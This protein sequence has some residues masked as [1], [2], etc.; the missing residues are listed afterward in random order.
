MPGIDLA[1][2][3]DRT[4]RRTLIERFGK[5]FVVSTCH[6]EPGMWESMVFLADAQTQTIANL[7]DVHCERHR[8]ATA[9]EAYAAHAHLTDT[10]LRF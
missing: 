3:Y 7:R 10:W 2:P 1:M 5:H 4:A 9:L 6:V 8:G